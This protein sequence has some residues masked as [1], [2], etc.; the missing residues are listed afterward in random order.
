MTAK[1]YLSSLNR[2]EVDIE[3]KIEQ[4]ARL[5]WI[6][7]ILSAL[8]AHALSVKPIAWAYPSSSSA[9]M[10][11]IVSVLNMRPFSGI[12]DQIRPAS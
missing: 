4:R 10:F 5:R 7:A 2:L 9:V 6:R 12:R 11:C 8:S 3:A 1:E